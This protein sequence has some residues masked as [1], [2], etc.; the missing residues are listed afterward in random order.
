MSNSPCWKRNP[1]PDRHPG[2]HCECN[3]YRQWEEEHS[4]ARDAQNKRRQLEEYPSI[5]RSYRINRFKRRKEI[6]V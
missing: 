6:G 3:D 5:M 4:K 2:C 1:C